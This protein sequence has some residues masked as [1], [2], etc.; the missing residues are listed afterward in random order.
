MTDDCWIWTFENSRY[1]Y[2]S[3]KGGGGGGGKESM[4]LE[5]KSE[6]GWIN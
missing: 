2:K 5:F 6:T 3:W 4:Y 1:T